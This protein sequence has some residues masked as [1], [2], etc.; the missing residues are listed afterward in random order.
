MIK[1]FDPFKCGRCETPLSSD[2]SQIL[3]HDGC[4]GETDVYDICIPCEVEWTRLSD[5][6]GYFEAKEKYQKQAYEFLRLDIE[7]NE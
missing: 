4:Y 3:I 6:T 2:Y 1:K 5:A 7:T